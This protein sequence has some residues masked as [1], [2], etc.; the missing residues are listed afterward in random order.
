[1]A[2]ENIA[3]RQS[4]G[5]A[6]PSPNGST[7]TATL[8]SAVLAGSALAVVGC[9]I[10]GNSGDG[11]AYQRTLLNSISDTSS[12]TWGTITNVNGGAYAPNV[13]GVLS[14]NVASGTPTVTL[15]LSNPGTNLVSYALLEIID[16]PA[17]GTL[18]QTPVSGST[19]DGV[20]EALA[21]V[22]QTGATG[23]LDQTHNLLLLVA[24]GYFGGPSNPAGWTE[25]HRT[26][27]GDG[28]T[29]GCQVSVK[30]VTTD[31]TVTGTVSHDDTGA[32][33]S[34][35]MYVI[36]ADT[37]GGT[38]RYKFQ[39]N[40][41]TLTS[42]DTGITG[43]VWRNSGPDG[44]FAEKYLD[45]AGAS[46]TAGDLYITSIPANAAVTDSVTGV[47]F[48]GTDTSGIVTGSVEEV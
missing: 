22:V 35:L 30:N 29:V 3:V 4:K 10:V 41:S 28:G 36:L 2:F 47:F 38:K 48:N 33:R 40:A 17:T 46:A 11:T 19:D 25:I 15:T 44:V 9:A 14:Q 26:T 23:T 20:G 6:P 27:N 12:N 45:L 31:T 13:F 18:A 34:A 21:G 24:G 1:M 7:V 43:Y 39:F 5:F 8:D 42:A 32:W 16:A 37:A